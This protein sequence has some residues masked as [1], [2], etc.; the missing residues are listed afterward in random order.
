[1]ER[2]AARF[3]RRQ[4]AVAQAAHGGLT[5]IGRL[6]SLSLEQGFACGSKTRL[7]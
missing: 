3:G 5:P 6:V 2:G 4:Q 7:H 1:M